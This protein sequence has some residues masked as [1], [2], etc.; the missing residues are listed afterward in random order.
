MKNRLGGIRL[1]I[2][3]EEA[4]MAPA[5][6]LSYFKETI[7]GIIIMATIAIPAV[8]EPHIAEINAAMNTVAMPMPPG[9][10]P[11]QDFMTFI[12]GLAEPP[13]T[14]MSPMKTK[15]GRA[16]IVKLLMP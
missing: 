7:S 14:N 12:R 3:P 8:D 6:P 11:T 1:A 4:T 15:R 5:K 9:I 10:R 13:S 2:L 16:S